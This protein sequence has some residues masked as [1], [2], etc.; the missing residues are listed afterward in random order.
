VT[1][2]VSV[3]VSLATFNSPPP[4][5]AAAFTTEFGALAETFT[6]NVIGG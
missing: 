6:V 3:T 1:T 5:T 2:V 4:L